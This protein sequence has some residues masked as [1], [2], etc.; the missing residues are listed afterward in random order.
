MFDPWNCQQIRICSPIPNSIHLCNI[1]ANAKTKMTFNFCHGA[2]ICQFFW[3]CP[4][5]LLF[6]RFKYG[7]W[8]MINAT[9]FSKHF[10]K[11]HKLV[12]MFQR[13]KIFEILIEL[14]C[15]RQIFVSVW[16][17]IVQQRVFVIRIRC[18]Q[19]HHV[20]GKTIPVLYSQ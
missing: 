19:I 16:N 3:K 14:I 5:L 10:N 8:P 6:T 18:Q 11:P 20:Y 13:Y 1:A 12:H 15:F 4:C 2:G 17:F 7:I 9:N